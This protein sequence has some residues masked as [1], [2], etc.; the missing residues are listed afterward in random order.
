MLPYKPETDWLFRFQRLACHILLGMSLCV[1]LI[2]ILL[3]VKPASVAY[4]DTFT[5]DT[6]DD[7]VDATPGD[8]LC[9]DAGGDCSL[10]AAIMEA[11]AMISDDTIILTSGVYTLTLS[12]SGEDNSLTGDLDVVTGTLIISGAGALNTVVD[13][14]QLDR[15]LHVQSGAV[16]RVYNVALT[17]GKTANVGLNGE[18]GGGVYNLGQ[19]TLMDCAISNNVTGDGSEAPDGGRGGHGGGVYNASHA[20]LTIKSSLVTHNATGNGGEGGDMGGTSGDGGSGG[21]IYN[22]G[23][24]SLTHSIV[25][26]NVTGQGGPCGGH[27]IAGIGGFGGGAYNAGVLT[28][29]RSTV[30]SNTAGPAGT[31]GIFN[32]GDGCGGGVSNRGVLSLINSTLSGNQANGSGGG[33]NN[34]WGG[35]LTIN[36]STIVTNVVDLNN[37]DDGVNPESGGGVYEHSSDVVNVK[38]SIIAGNIEMNEGAQDCDG[39]I[40]SQG[41]NLVGEGTGCPTDGPGDLTVDPDDVFV[42]VLGSLRDNGGD[43]LTHALLPG[44]PAIDAGHPAPPGSG[45]DACL[46]TDQRG[47]NRF[48]CDSGAFEL[49]NSLAIRKAGTPW[50]LAPGE[51]LTYTLVYTNHSQQTALDVLITDTLPL[52]LTVV[53]VARSGPPITPTGDVSFTWQV[54]AIEPGTSGAITL[55]TVVS[56]LFGSTFTLTNRALITSTNPA[57]V[58]E[59]LDDNV[60]VVHTLVDGEPPLPP[61]LLRPTDGTLTHTTEL[62]L[63]WSASPNSDVLGYLL[64]W[65]GAPTDVG[66]VT[67]YK[68]TVLADGLYTWTVAAYDSLGNTSFYTSVWTFTVDGT[69]PQVL[70]F[71]PEAGETGV[72][73][74]AP[75]LITFSEAIN[76]DGFDYLATPNPGGWSATRSGDGAAVSLEHTPFAYQTTYTFTVSAAY[77]LAGNP[78]SDAPVQWTFTTTAEP[79]TQVVGVDLTL[80]TTGIIY[81]GQPV[82]FQAAISPDDLTPPYTYVID[83]GD[84]TV[85]SSTASLNP[86]PLTH[87]YAATGSHQATIGVWNCAMSEPVTDSVLVEVYS[88]EPT[89]TEVTDVAL[90][91]TNTAPIYVGDAVYFQADLLP[92]E[93]DPDYHYIVTLDGAAGETTRSGVEPSTFQHSFDTSGTHTV[94]VAVW[95]CDMTVPNLVTAAIEVD[96]YPL[97]VCVPISGIT[98]APTQA[99]Q[100]SPITFTPTITPREASP[101]IDYLWDFGDGSPPVSGPDPTHTYE[102][103][104]NTVTLT[105]GNACSQRIISQSVSVALYDCCVSPQVRFDHSLPLSVGTPITFSN[106]TTWCTVYPITYTWGFGDGSPPL[107]AVDA[108]HT[109]SVA[110]RFTVW[111]SANMNCGCGEW[112]SGVYSRTLS[113]VG[114]PAYRVY[115]PVVL[116]ND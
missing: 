94:E 37:D 4:A 106:T 31:G 108:T 79:C 101:P 107:T 35:A 59:T 18:S 27:C 23:T 24:M 7:T 115:L 88:E 9:G 21:G 49:L 75:V 2:L 56:P 90:S 66:D 87:T 91:Y 30:N 19:L 83:Y 84:D 71:A 51:V 43:T 65:N 55:T 33:V 42:T 113:L 54:G 69:P 82:T 45:G 3:A 38:N 62:T 73:I 47:E 46:P 105:A 11:N 114:M 98:F 76:T 96:V 44:S 80:V 77:D 58:D 53:D 86:L 112:R 64:D 8:G 50:A 61:G 81:P 40:N 102:C 99:V 6:S 22:A 103:G 28:L 109:Y 10:R 15:V 5:V 26:N 17:N 16:V 111:L 68:V 100:F 63:T 74:N 20:T 32:L 89:C 34:V 93:A 41:Y 29:T 12:G 116:K 95:N 1:A 36:N 70:D 39:N 67:Q 110:G 104:P 97:D 13:G 25:S 52:S 48:V 57:Y 78:L 14:N 92:D 72:T 85:I 60:S